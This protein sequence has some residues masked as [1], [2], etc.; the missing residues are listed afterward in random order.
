MAGSPPQQRLV[1]LLPYKMQ[2]IFPKAEIVHGSKP[3]AGLELPSYLLSM[4][5]IDQ[6]FV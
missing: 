5:P 4:W 3:F 6:N 1:L 2:E